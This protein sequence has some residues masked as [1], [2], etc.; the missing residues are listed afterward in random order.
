M[1]IRW[2]FL[3]C[4]PNTLGEKDKFQSVGEEFVNFLT[5]KNLKNFEKSIDV[6]YQVCYNKYVKRG[7]DKTKHKKTAPLWETLTEKSCK[8]F[9]NPS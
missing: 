7:K 8:F 5:I 9:Q 2:Y 3:Y 1:K 4:P 6:L